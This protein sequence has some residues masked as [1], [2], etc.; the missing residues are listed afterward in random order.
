MGGYELKDVLGEG[1]MGT[2]YRAY[3]PTLDR[4][5]AVKVIRA[6]AL[7]R[8]GKERFLREARACSK[9]SHPNIITVYAAGEEN[10]EPY[11]AMEF[12]DGE[13]LR[14]IINKGPLDWRTATRWIVALLDALQ[15]LHTEGIVHR[16]LKPENIMVTRDGT[17][18]LMDFGLVHLT[19]ETALTQEGTTM[20]TVPYMSP[21]QVMGKRLDARS[22]LFSL[23]TIYH[24]MLTGMHPFRGDHPMAVMYSI[25]NDTPRPIKL[26]SSDY[27]VG[28]QGVLDCA[29]AKEIDKRYP[30]AATFRDAILA[31]APEL[32]G[33]TIIERK[34]SP[35]RMALTVGL[36]SA[37][38]FGV[39]LTGWNIVQGR[40]AA[41]NRAAAQNL[42]ERAMLA[43]THDAKEDLLRQALQTDPAYAPPYN[44]LGV[45][46]LEDGFP[47]VADS[48]FHQALQRS[49]RFSAALL[50][51]GNR[52]FDQQRYDSAEVYYRRAMRGND[53]DAGVVAN[54]FAAVLLAQDKPAEARG[55]I[56]GV[57]ENERRAEIRS[58]LLMNLGKALAAEGD[59]TAAR[60]RWKEAKGINPEIPVPV[61]DL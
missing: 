8:E 58:Y 43:A 38:V 17:V 18:K 23:A 11:M 50:N 48:L 57:L 2:V 36:V 33:T 1:G 39:G 10:S 45:M 60:E 34:S 30:D 5:A 37:I 52:Y 21:E 40:R 9:I 19:T 35:V 27:P 15:R 28:L 53:A 6:K 47:Q 22:D 56:E 32:T 25:R 12:I 3:D 44:E 49:P 61:P 59:S 7:S 55:L 14:D 29:F 41:A 51:V 24:E 46:A 42:N 31:V 4:P 54:Q 16:D 20:G 26:E 13:T